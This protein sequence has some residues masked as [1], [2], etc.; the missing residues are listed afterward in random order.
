MNLFLAA[1]IF[2]L[3]VIVLSALRNRLVH[4]F[5]GSSLLIFGSQNPGLWFYSLLFLPGT[6]LHELSHWIVAEILQVRTG[7]INIF[8]DLG[9][10]GGTK[11][12]G[13]VATASSGPFRSFLIGIAPFLSGIFTLSLLGYFLFLGGLLW[14][15]YALLIY[16]TAVIG[17]SMLLSAE[18]RRTWPFII[19]FVI[20]LI[21]LLNQLNLSLPPIFLAKIIT[22][23]VS[24]N[25]V[26]GVT[27]GI[28][29]VMIGI[30]YTLRRIIEV[31]T[32]KKLTRR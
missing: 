3:L 26:L 16:A 6:I 5:V 17:S 1:T 9:S 30:L 7:E 31:L 11:K 20:V 28:I 2:V 25:K 27:V 13:S 32:H 22:V 14:W 10:E 8:P 15:Q 21:F 29:L 4:E 12:L 23:L 19:I 24:L 18:D